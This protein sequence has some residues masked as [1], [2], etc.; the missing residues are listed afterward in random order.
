MSI[1]LHWGMGLTKYCTSAEMGNT[2]ARSNMARNKLM[3]YVGQVESE[4]SVT[5]PRED[6]QQAAGNTVVPLS[7]GDT[8]QDL[9][10]MP[11]IM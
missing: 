3:N 7:S 11:E 2:E 1:F 5:Q 8:F 6:T 10:W 9:P 4:R